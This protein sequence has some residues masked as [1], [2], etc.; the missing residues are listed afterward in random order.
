MALLEIKG[1]QISLSSIYDGLFLFYLRFEIPLF[2]AD[3][4]IVRW[5]E[6][7]LIKLFLYEA[8]EDSL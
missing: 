4:N 6:S 5:K 3:L 2:C 8:C 7:Q 1:Q